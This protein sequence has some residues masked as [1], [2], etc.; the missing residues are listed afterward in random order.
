MNSLPFLN[1]FLIILA[2]AALI[3][4]VSRPLRLPNVVG[5]LLTG[6]LIGP[7]GELEKS[8]ANEVIP[9]EFETSIEI[10]T[11]V[12]EQYRIPR[13]VVNAQI[14]V[15]RDENYSMLRGLP[16]TSRGLERVAQLLAAGTADTFLVI[17]G[18]TAAGKTVRELDLATKTDA[19]IIAVVRGDKPIVNPPRLSLGASRHAGAGRY[20]RQHGQSL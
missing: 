10:F 5:F 9:E 13:N 19:N 12:L 4:F 2:A 17:D 6:L 18:T 3:I 15:I 8:G 1:D 14:K 7:S 20:P 11:R 16:Q